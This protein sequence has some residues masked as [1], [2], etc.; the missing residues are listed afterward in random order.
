MTSRHD[1]LH[2]TKDTCMLIF[3]YLT[4]KELGWIISR[5]SSRFQLLA[6]P[7]LYFERADCHFDTLRGAI[8]VTDP[9]CDQRADFELLSRSRFSKQCTLR[10]RRNVS[11]EGVV[12][13]VQRMSCSSFHS[14]QMQRLQALFRDPLFKRQVILTRVGWGAF[15]FAFFVF[16]K[17]NQC[18]C[19]ELVSTSYEDE[20]AQVYQVL[21]PVLGCPCYGDD[22]EARKLTSVKVC[23]KHHIPDTIVTFD[24]RKA[25]WVTSFKP[26]ATGEPDPRLAQHFLDC[27]S[28]LEG[29]ATAATD[30]AWTAADLAKAHR[31]L[32]ILLGINEQARHDLKKELLARDEPPGD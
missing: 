8:T 30:V 32:T 27:C 19:F 29:S 16:L 13:V 14:A 15:Y 23:T 20:C 28:R 26:S 1:L 24:V 25:M 4:T 17:S 9:S 2:Q 31:D 6:T 7:L 5:L 10:A 22:F 21:R 3:S 12:E 11:F 18:V